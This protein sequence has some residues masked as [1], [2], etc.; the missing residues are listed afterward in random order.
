MTDPSTSLGQA[1]PTGTI[2]FLFTD[3]EGSTRRWEEHPIAMQVDLARHDILMHKAIE[4]HDGFVFKTIGDAFCAAFATAP[5]A[6]SAAIMAQQLLLAESWGEGGPLRARMALHTGVAEVR[7]RDYF[8]QPVNR[9]ARLL[10]AGHGGQTLLS[11]TAY[12]LV[13]DA[14]PEGVRLRDLG[15]HRLKDLQRPE[16]VFQLLQQALPADFP[17]LR[18]LDNHPN[19]LPMQPTPLIGRSEDLAA[20]CNRLRRQHLRLLTLTGPGGTGKTRLGLQVAADLLDDFPDGVFFIPLASITN[21][22]LVASAIAHTLGVREAEGQPLA[23]R[24]KDYLREKQLLLLLDNF[25]QVLASAPL[26]ADLLATCLQ[27]TVLVTSR[28]PLH[29]RR[30]QEFPVP[31]LA[32]PDARRQYTAETLSQYAAV[33]LFIERA[34]AVKPDFAV[35]N[36]N[37]PAVAEICARL[38]G[39]PLAIELAAARSKVL[40]PRAMLSRLG[41]RLSILTGGARD[42]PLRQQTLRAVLDWSYD[43]LNDREQTLFPRLAVFAGGFTL[44]AA[45]AVCPALGELEIDVLDV[46][47]SLVDKSL[48]RQDEQADGDVRFVVLETVRE[49]ALERL[50]QSQEA[51]ALERQHAAY[52]L[53]LAEEESRH[54][55]GPQQGTWRERL[56]RENDNMRAA[57]RWFIAS[58]EAEQGLRLA[59]A[60]RSFWAQGGYLSEGRAWLAEL[61]AMP[62]ALA[63]ATERA[64]A[65]LNAGDLARLQ[66]EYAE[67]R[68]CCE[69]SLAILQELGDRRGV[70][71]ALFSLG[72]VAL[73]QDDD[74][75]ARSLMEES[76]AIRQELG[77]PAAIAEVLGRGLGNLAL[78]QGNYDAARTLFEKALAIFR[79][80]KD[81]RM[82]AMML[83]SLG[84]VAQREGDD[85]R[86]ETLYQESLKLTRIGGAKPLLAGQLF[87]LGCMALMR[88]DFAAARALF[89]ECLALE[90]EMGHRQGLAGA[91]NC[92]GDVARFQGNYAGARTY[93]EESLALCRAKEA[94]PYIAVLLHSLGHVALHQGDSRRAQMLFVEGLALQ[95][96]FSHQQHINEFLAG[97]AAVAAIDGAP[98]R[99]ARLFGAAE[100]SLKTSDDRLDFVDFGEDDRNLASLRAQLDTEVFAAAWA[101]GQAM[102]LEQA[103]SYGLE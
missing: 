23:E 103:I 60:L 102:T 75:T 21:P 16:Q 9:V 37:A 56:E 52:Y 14:L 36:D 54:L 50:A 89:E 58:N 25:E 41:H 31:P 94:K 69:A 40:P 83:S 95:G 4:S 34:L 98:D 90:R 66:G 24:L 28:A 47:E 7:D 2:T 26:V 33:A 44:G 30:E 22:D 68:V 80:L 91:L 42:L 86:A 78:G 38:D 64:W 101:E 92:L 49:Y 100:A 88:R 72:M 76:L 79:D 32:L 46:M 18:T 96:E 15:Q 39:L 17:A 1:L 71:T 45:E 55:K 97:L 82:S 73:A 8:G 10:A 57:L 61:L 65:M 77:Q 53:R 43:L 62:A 19:N 81:A 51:E 6:L 59:G 35:T 13:R 63:P 70:A 11:Q 29:L 3:I 5:D 67:A 27:L 85:Q 84:H 74:A 93:Y 99:A 48:V 20:A 12:D 87:D